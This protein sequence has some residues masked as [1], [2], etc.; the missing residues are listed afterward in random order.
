M[1]TNMHPFPMVQESN[2]HCHDIVS[3]VSITQSH[4]LS[5]QHP[6]TSKP[7]RLY[8]FFINSKIIVQY[9]FALCNNN[10]STIDIVCM[11]AWQSKCDKNIKLVCVAFAWISVVVVAVSLWSLQR[12]N[13]TNITTNLLSS[14]LRI[15]RTVAV[16]VIQYYTRESGR[17]WNQKSCD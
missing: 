3:V 16:P 14:L 7:T 6:F 9:S 17:A 5:V 11:C 8:Q 1:I 15:P 12:T 10:R 2:T 4:A 13:K